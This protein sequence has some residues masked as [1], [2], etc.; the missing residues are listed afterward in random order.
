[1]RATKVARFDKNLTSSSPILPPLRTQIIS[2]IFQCLYKRPNQTV[3]LTGHSMGGAIVT[4]V[5]LD[6]A[7]NFS[8]KPVVI[9]FG[10]PKTGDSVFVSAYNNNIDYSL[11]VI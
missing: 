4:M 7:L 2:T 6:L 11:R 9:T 1:M 8:I 3:Y 10:S 5:A